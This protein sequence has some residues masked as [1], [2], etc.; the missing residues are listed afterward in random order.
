MPRQKSSSTEEDTITWDMLT[1][2]PC[3]GLVATFWHRCQEPICW[4]QLD[5][6][7]TESMRKAEQKSGPKFQFLEFSQN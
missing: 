2:L 5:S 6:V 7:Q 3:E 4:D 1:F